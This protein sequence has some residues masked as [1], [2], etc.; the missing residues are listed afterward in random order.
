MAQLAR[1]FSFVMY[2]YAPDLTFG[3]PFPYLD[4]QHVR[5][6]AGEPGT[7]VEVTPTW[8][9]SATLA[10]PAETPDGVPIPPNAPITIRRFTPR[11]RVMVTYQDGAQLP[12]ADL[13][14]ATQQLL[15]IIQESIDFGTYGGSGLPG[16]GSGWTDGNVP[17]DPQIQEIIDRIFASDVFKQ[18]VL[19]PL[20]RIDTAAETLLEEILRSDEYFTGIRTLESVSDTTVTQVTQL[21][22]RMDGAEAGVIA[23]KQATVDEASARASAIEQVRAEFAAA[24]DSLN[25]AIATTLTESYATKDYAQATAETK[26]DALANGAVAHIEERFQALAT[27]S[28][29]PDNAFSAVW[30]IR[31]VGTAGG[32]PVIAGVGLGIDPQTGSSF[33]VSADQFAIVH[34]SYTQGGAFAT[35]KFPFVVGLVGGVTQVGIDGNLV[36]DK[37]IKANHISVNSLSAITGNLG[38]VNSGTFRTY[39]LDANGAIINPNE[40]RVEITN[41]VNDTWPLWVGS[42]VKNANNAVFWL[43]RSGNASFKGKVQANNMMGSLQR[44]VSVDISTDQGAAYG[45]DVILASF[46][47]P[48]PV[49]LGE[50]HVPFV[51]IMVNHDQAMGTECYIEYQAP[52]GSWQ[53][54]AETHADVVGGSS[55]ARNYRTSEMLV[56]VSPGTASATNF[57]VRFKHFYSGVNVVTHSVRGAAL[58]IR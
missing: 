43:D 25:T 37:T 54:I 47:L 7:A 28:A 30:S 17:P 49:L 21:G 48:A 44:S 58:G 57:R 31:M 13:N 26:V 19:D 1:G 45:Q 24:D 5:V 32:K 33:I 38:T 18:V 23:A 16:G 55:D 15:Y 50:S 36:V 29:D 27:G 12:A 52:G 20:P 42:G 35:A 9:T 53:I 6:F 51:S 3:I 40:F 10:V 11:D 34:P 14:L 56:G 46:T 39:N 22:V 8:A 4:P 2:E 41:N